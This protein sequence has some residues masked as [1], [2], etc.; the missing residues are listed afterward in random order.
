MDTLSAEE[1]VERIKPHLEAAGLD[2]LSIKVE[3]TGEPPFDEQP[4]ANVRVKLTGP[5]SRTHRKMIAAERSMSTAFRNDIRSGYYD[6]K[7]GYEMPADEALLQFDCLPFLL[8]QP[9]AP[10]P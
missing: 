2:V 4:T 1:I 6:A 3:P 7:I 9:S 8:S 10:R 5:S